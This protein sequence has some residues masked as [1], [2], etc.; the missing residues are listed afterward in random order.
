M[1]LLAAV[2]VLVIVF[3]RELEAATVPP[4]DLG[5]NGGTMED[6]IQRISR[7][8]ARQ[9][10]FYILNSRAYRNHN[11]GNLTLDITGGGIGIGYDGAYVIYP[12]DESGWADLHAQVRM[13]LTGTSRFYKPWMTIREVSKIYTATQQD[14][15]SRNVASFLGVSEDTKLSEV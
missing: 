12:D 3:R 7:A 8:I 15:W 2:I 11:P 10:G 1:I 6:R 5:E 9:E 4:K 14:A 13:M